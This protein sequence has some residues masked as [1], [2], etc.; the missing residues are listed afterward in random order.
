[1]IVFRQTRLNAVNE[2][3]INWFGAGLAADSNNFRDGPH[4]H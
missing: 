3:A 1:M 2:L 4:I